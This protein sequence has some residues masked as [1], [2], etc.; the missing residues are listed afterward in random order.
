MKPQSIT[1]YYLPM[2]C[3]DHFYPSKIE[4]D[5]EIKIIVDMLGLNRA[6]KRKGK[7]N[8]NLLLVDAG[9]FSQWEPWL[10]TI[11]C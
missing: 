7:E 9:D 2:I 1:I 6:I 8:P 11:F 3:M 10:Q 5:G 4:E